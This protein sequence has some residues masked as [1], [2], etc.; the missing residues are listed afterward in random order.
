MV[1]CYLTRKYNTFVLKVVDDAVFG[2]FDVME[3]IDKALNFYTNEL[4]QVI[5]EVKTDIQTFRR[6]SQSQTLLCSLV[7]D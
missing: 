3:A 4:V 6:L 2:L 1:S 7:G 5:M